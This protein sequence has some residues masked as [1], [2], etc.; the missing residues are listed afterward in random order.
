MAI[1]VHLP[2]AMGNELGT[3][4]MMSAGLMREK[5]LE[6]VNFFRNLMVAGALLGFAQFIA[7]D[8][9]VIG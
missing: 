2:G 1:L 6:R 8:N 5:E 3:E 4:T 9:R 7:K